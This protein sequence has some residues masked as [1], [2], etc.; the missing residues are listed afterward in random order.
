MMQQ[1]SLLSRQAAQVDLALHLR[2]L[3]RRAVQRRVDRRVLQGLLEAV[4][5]YLEAVA[6][7]F[8]HRLRML[9]PEQLVPLVGNCCL[10][11]LVQLALASLGFSERASGGDKQA[12][13]LPINS[14][15]C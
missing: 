12:Y 1:V 14:T 6:P 3:Q 4:S 9:H 10:A 11:L 8:Q 7:L 13:V 2:L 5:P 15:S